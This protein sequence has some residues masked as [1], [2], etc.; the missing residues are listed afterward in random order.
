LLTTSG[1]MEMPP[2]YNLWLRCDQGNSKTIYHTSDPM[3]IVMDSHDLGF[4]S[5]N[6]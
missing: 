6:G 3:T 2:T 5:I 1:T 4:S